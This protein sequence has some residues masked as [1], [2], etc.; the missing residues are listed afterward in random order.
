MKRILITGNAGY[1][2]SHLSKLLSTEYH[3]YGMDQSEN[4]APV[5]SHSLTNIC[6]LT[7]VDMPFDT[8]IHLAALVQVNESVRDP[9]NYYNTNINGTLKVLKNIKFNNFVFAS[10]GTAEHCHS[11][12]GISKRAAEDC[13]RQV[14]EEAHVGYTIFRF[15]N[16]IGS[17]GFLPTN[18]DGLFYNLIKARETGE[19]TIFGN[20]YD[21]PDGTCIR[22]YVHVNEICDALR[23]AIEKPSNSIECLGHGVGY[24]VA[25]ILNKFKEVNNIPNIN[26]LTKIGPRRRGDLASSVLA[27]VSPYMKNLYSIEQLLKV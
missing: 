5:V 22:D 15:Y 18:P 6:N 20:D 16:V 4:I 8:V 7:P 12:Y 10:T 21:T 25:E 3:V 14:C 13:V 26:L 23:T 11:P 9:I 24:T 19:F 1:I 27:E 2:G 17:D